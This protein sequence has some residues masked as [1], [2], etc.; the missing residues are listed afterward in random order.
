MKPL[1]MHNGSVCD[2][3]GRRQ[4]TLLW[5]PL[6]RGYVILDKDKVYPAIST[7]DIRAAFGSI[8]LV[9]FVKPS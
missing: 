1:K 8:T 3:D 6:S 2:S 5:Y 9:D 4:A 7:F